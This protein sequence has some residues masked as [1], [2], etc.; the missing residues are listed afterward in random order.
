MNKT[1]T[2]ILV[3]VIA[4]LVI[5]GLGSLSDTPSQDNV[6]TTPVSSQDW[7]KGNQEAPLTLVEYGDFQCPACAAYHPILKS[8]EAEFG[9]NLRGVFRHFPL[10]IHAN[11]QLASQA[12]EAAGNQGKFW[13]MH[14]LLFEHQGD[15][16]N[17]SNT[18]AKNMFMGFAGQL[19]LNLDTFGADL[20]AQ[21]TIV[22]I[23]E[24]VQSGLDA[25]VTATPTFFLN[26]QK[27]T[28]PQG[29]EPFRNLLNTLL[30]ENTPN[31][32]DHQPQ[33]TQAATEE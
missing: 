3:I 29:L 33:E 16:A 17:L 31:Q 23:Q 27:I 20:D 28:N 5:L 19:E 1:F 15:W 7:V 22:R 25:N 13:E 9:E 32:E 12:A 8:L 10:I 26:G 30:E 18:E 21:E 14:D 11:A 6:L 4:V 24:D 2:I